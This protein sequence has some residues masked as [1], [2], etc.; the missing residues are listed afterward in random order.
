MNR[1]EKLIPLRPTIDTIKKGN[2]SEIEGFQNGVLRPILKFQHRLNWA[3][4]KGNINFQKL[5]AAAKPDANLELLIQNF[6]QKDRAFRAQLLGQI[7]GLLT[8]EEWSF[9]EQHNSECNRRILQMQTQRFWDSLEVL[10]K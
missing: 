8:L 2:S 7:T 9:Y 3:L 10:E 6:I 5:R 4:L 1:F